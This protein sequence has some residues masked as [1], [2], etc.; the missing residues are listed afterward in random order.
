MKPNCHRLI[1]SAFKLDENIF[2][3]YYERLVKHL[4]E[5]YPAFDQQTN[6]R[7]VSE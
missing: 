3:P 1:I 7:T 2:E 6:L 4:A 5:S